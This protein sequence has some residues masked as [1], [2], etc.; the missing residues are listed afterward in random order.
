[1]SVRQDV[2]EPV[3]ERAVVVEA[4]AL[5]GLQARGPVY[6]GSTQITAGLRFEHFTSVTWPSLATAS[7]RTVHAAALVGAGAAVPRLTA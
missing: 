5:V 4:V 7:P 1:M 6:G 2:G 3:P